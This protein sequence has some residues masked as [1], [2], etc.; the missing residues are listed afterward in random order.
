MKKRIEFT[1]GLSLRTKSIA[2]CFLVQAVMLSILIWNNLQ[3]MENT[4]N[5]QFKLHLKRK[6]SAL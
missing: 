2:A 6:S 3:V 4:L 1:S 5:E